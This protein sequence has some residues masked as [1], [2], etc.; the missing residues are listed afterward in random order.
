MGQ[1]N[2][3]NNRILVSA[4]LVY[5]LV[6]T[7]I[8][9]GTSV[10]STEIVL[11]CGW[12]EGIIGMASSMS[13]LGISSFCL[14]GG[15]IEQRTGFRKV[16]LCGSLLGAA[17]YFAMALWYGNP[18]LYLAVFGCVGISSALCG[19]TSG[20]GLINA[21]FGDKS[22]FQ[23]AILMTAG[24]VG[25]FIMPVAAQC[26]LGY[27]ITFCWA[28]YACMCLAAFLIEY[29]LLKDRPGRF[30]AR[31]ECRKRI[32]KRKTA[33]RDYYLSKTF[34]CLILEQ[35]GMKAVGVGINSYVVLYAIQN[36]AS[37]MQA[38]F[39]ATVFGAANFA[40]RLAVG[41]SSC[42]PVTKQQV[43]ML[44]VFLGS[45]GCFLLWRASG[46]PALLLGTG[47][48]GLGF[49]VISALKPILV[50]TCFGS[51]NFPAMNGSYEAISTVGSVAA[52]M[53]VYGVAGLCGGYQYAYLTLGIYTAFCFLLACRT[54]IERVK[55]ARVCPQVRGTCSAVVEEK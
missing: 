33:L 44:S 23:M 36:G 16:M 51:E 15:F 5:F 10:I 30:A 25:G 21:W 41:W 42:L 26:L 6:S 18:Y 27:G 43:N 32:K 8:S 24:S 50:A 48:A 12:N 35:L 1:Q 38:A 54:R 9:Y 3:G 47:T 29:F 13:Y 53:I 14:I 55:G 28:V 49:G 45:A 34:L 20:P 40:G 4:W 39:L 2:R 7:P 11:Q 19:I 52:P 37:A 22:T 46:Y 17:A 31:P